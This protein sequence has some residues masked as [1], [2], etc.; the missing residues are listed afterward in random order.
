MIEARQIMTVVI[1]LMLLVIGIFVVGVVTT[2][3]DAVALDYSGTFPV[4][5][6]TVDQNCDTGETG[7]TGI[8]VQKYDAVRGW[9]SVGSAFVSYSG[10]T[11]T[12]TS[13]GLT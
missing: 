12:V 7:L 11:V 4:S 8:S 2:A 13:G 3:N 5:D 1:C 6:P 10:S 9:T